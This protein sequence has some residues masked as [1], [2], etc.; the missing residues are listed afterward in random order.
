MAAKTCGA[1]IF[2]VIDRVPEVKNDKDCESGIGFQLNK[3]IDFKNV[4]FKYPTQPAEFKPVLEDATFSI[5]AGETTA[6]VGPSGSG[7]STIIQ[8]VER[9]YDPV[10]GGSV[11]FDGKDLKK[12]DLR[13]L[14]E[15][16][17]YVGQEPTMILGTIKDNLL[18]GNRHANDG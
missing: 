9:F 16:I 4:T 8:L 5:K 10:V 18:F 12:I 13:D 11:C 1:L 6:I 7:K 3:S 15:N 17:G 2:D 14:R